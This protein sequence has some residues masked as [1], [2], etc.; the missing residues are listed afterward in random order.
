MEQEEIA[1]VNK[2]GGMDMIRRVHA[3]VQAQSVGGCQ[4]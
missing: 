4:R 3:H 1:G 2:Q